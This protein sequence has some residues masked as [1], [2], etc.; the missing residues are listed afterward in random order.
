MG[1]RSKKQGGSRRKQGN[2]TRDDLEDELK[3][4][5]KFSAQ[6]DDFKRM[7]LL[8]DQ[9]DAKIIAKKKLPAKKLKQL[10]DMVDLNSGDFSNPHEMSLESVFMN[11]KYPNRRSRD[12]QMAREARF[13]AKNRLEMLKHQSRKMPIEFVKAKEVY[14]PSKMMIDQ[15]LKDAKANKGIH[16]AQEDPTTVNEVEI[17]EPVIEEEKELEEEV[18][19]IIDE[20]DSSEIIVPDILPDSESE[21][22]SDSEEIN[23]PTMMFSRIKVKQGPKQQMMFIDDNNSEEFELSLDEDSESESDDEIEE[24]I[25]EYE[26]NPEFNTTDSDSDNE[27]QIGKFS[28]QLK[29]DTLGNQYIDLPLGKSGKR[30]LPPAKEE[31]VYDFDKENDDLTID[32]VEKQVHSKM[33]G[34]NQKSKLIDTTKDSD[35]IE[36]GFSEEDYVSFDIS[37]IR[38]DNIRSSGDSHTQY[39]IQAPMLLGVEDFQWLT[40]DDISLFLIENGLP[41]SRVDPFLKYSIKHLVAPDESDSEEELIYYDEEL[42]LQS[43]SDEDIQS[44][45]SSELDEYLMEG[46]EDL[47]KMHKSSQ[48][49]GRT[50]DPLDVNTRSISAKGKRTDNK[51]TFELEFNIDSPLDPEL[52]KYMED[53]YLKRKMNK[54]FNKEEREEARRTD[55]Y[56]L[57]KYPYCIEMDEVVEEFKLFFKDPI[58]ETLRFPPLDFNAHMV[59]R[60]ISDA[61]HFSSKKM[62][63]GK[64]E[65]VQVRKS[66]SRQPREPNWNQIDKLRKRR[67]LCFRMDAK[68]SKE[69]MRLFTRV[70]NGDKSSW[71]STPKKGGKAQ[72]GYKEGE[73]VGANSRELP[74]DSI[75]RKLLQ[76]MGWNDGDALGVEGNKGII[77]PIKVVVK[78]T[79]RGI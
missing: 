34:T 69:E 75:G 33:A 59:L 40:K 57:N 8:R 64:K 51:D 26:E 49:F 79:K 56:L 73:I 24:D 39:F 13:T 62:G 23:E 14:N 27:F 3:T 48:A 42:Q 22:D 16:I 29:T 63:K 2:K 53:M 30:W 70:K 6:S 72:F 9:R 21:S 36:F 44:D 25:A 20:S 4:Y 61:F 28:G 52:K 71:K 10:N 77:E 38:I 17:V 45:A 32:E 35:E 7:K 31:V 12:G 67:K 43:S 58:V 78:T 47:L 76:M 11:K 46:M 68:L 41:K 1:K 19:I 60:A 55:S 15:L 65:H 50:M 74:Q 5:G 66:V 54:K 37:S 18:D